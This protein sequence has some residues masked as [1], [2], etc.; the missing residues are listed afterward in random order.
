MLT[1]VEFIHS[2]DLQHQD[3]K[4]ES[5]FL[6]PDGQVKLGDFGIGKVNQYIC[7]VGAEYYKAPEVLKKDSQIGNESDIWGLGLIMHELATRKKT[8]RSE[9]ITQ[10]SIDEVK[11]R[12]TKYFPRRLPQSLSRELRYSI[13]YMLSKEIK[14]RPST[15]KLLSMEIL[16]KND[17]KK[18]EIIEPFMNGSKIITVVKTD[19]LNCQTPA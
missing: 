4:P 19:P 9:D 3:L 17:D 12:I 1:G 18:E 14:H 15:Q 11:E 8:F 6:M 10:N 2:K 5:I 16:R 13:Y 7:D